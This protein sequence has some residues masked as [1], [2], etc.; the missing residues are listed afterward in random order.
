MAGEE[1][2]AVPFKRALELDHA[3]TRPRRMPARHVGAMGQWNA[4][5]SHD[6]PALVTS[7]PQRHDVAA[8]LQNRLTSHSSRG[9]RC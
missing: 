5:C 9:Q 2:D 8:N 3:V 6:R 1:A 4:A 7:R